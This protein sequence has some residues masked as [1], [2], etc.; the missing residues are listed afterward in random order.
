MTQAS[1]PSSTPRVPLQV[2]A[3]GKVDTR[4]YGT[5]R[6]RTYRLI[7]AIFLLATTLRLLV[8]TVQEVRHHAEVLSAGLPFLGLAALSLWLGINQVRRL[9]GR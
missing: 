6:V 9:V 7:A 1:S 5:R 4:A 3:K 2:L 8:I